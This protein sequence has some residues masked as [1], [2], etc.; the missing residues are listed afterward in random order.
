VIG[1][2]KSVEGWGWKQTTKF[3]MFS[4]TLVSFYYLMYNHANK[5]DLRF[6]KQLRGVNERSNGDRIIFKHY[7]L[8]G[9]I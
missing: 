9:L 7:N 8:I 5:N 1:G 2:E 6:L 3:V 4:T